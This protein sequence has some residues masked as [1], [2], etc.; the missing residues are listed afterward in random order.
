MGVLTPGSAHARPSLQPT[1][2][3]SGNF[4]AHLSAESL[5]YISHNCLELI[6]KVSEN[7]KNFKK[8]DVGFWYGFEI[9]HGLLSNKIIRIPMK[10]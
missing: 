4:P 5:S 1:I 8:W 10:K 9:L 7:Y 3:V 2:D 6:S